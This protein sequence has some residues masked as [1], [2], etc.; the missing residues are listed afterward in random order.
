MESSRLFLLRSVLNVKK[1]LRK[2]SVKRI[3]YSSYDIRKYI[4]K[5][6]LSR[7]VEYVSSRRSTVYP[8]CS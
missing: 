4:E 2:A 6:P 5:S 1:A 3:I 7:G 8:S